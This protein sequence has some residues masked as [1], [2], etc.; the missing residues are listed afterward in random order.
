[1]DG[2]RA[3][4]LLYARFSRIERIDK[5]IGFRLALGIRVVTCGFCMGWQ[6]YGLFIEI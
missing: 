3:Y 2:L 6:A 1:M 4:G 5:G